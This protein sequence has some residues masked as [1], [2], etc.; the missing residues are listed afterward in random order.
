MKNEETNYKVMLDMLENLKEQTETYTN[1]V[2]QQLENNG[3]S[4]YKLRETLTDYTEED[5][6]IIDIKVLRDIMESAVVND[7]LFNAGFDGYTEI[8]KETAGY[9][10]YLRDTAIDALRSINDVISSENEVN[11]LQKN[12]DE[13]VAEY[14]EYL[15]SDKYYEENMKRIEK[16]KNDLN[17]EKDPKMKEKIGNMIDAMENRYTL[18]F[19][20]KRLNE[21][22]DK[23]VDRLVD[24]FFD[25]NRSQ[26]IMKRYKTKTE[27]LG[28]HPDVYKYFLNLEEK[29]LEEKYYVFNNLFV[30]V[31][32]NFIAYIDVYNTRDKMYAQS[33]INSMANVVYEKFPNEK[34]KQD[35]LNIMRRV[36]DFFENYREVFNEKN[37]LH[38]NHPRRIE[39]D[40]E[41]EKELREMIYSNLEHI[42]TEVNRDMSIDDLKKYYQDKLD[43]FEAEEK[44]KVQKTKRIPAFKDDEY[45]KVQQLSFVNN[46]NELECD[47]NSIKSIED[48]AIH[49][50]WIFRTMRIDGF[51]TV[52]IYENFKSESNASY[53]VTIVDEKTNYIGTYKYYIEA[54]DGK[55]YID[56]DYIRYIIAS[57]RRNLPNAKYITD[58][59][60]SEDGV[61]T[62]TND[63][64]LKA[65]N[66]FHELLR[67]CTCFMLP[68]CVI[69]DMHRTQIRGDEILPKPGLYNMSF[70]AYLYAISLNE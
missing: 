50:S 26:Y 41:R 57:I 42:G 47:E 51:Y 43:E 23:E 29:Y 56:A 30:F 5:L 11:D 62:I 52:G 70:M 38:P 58:V 2:K 16:L 39:K 40:K 19:M 61:Y 44:V 22:G 35:F 65:L 17:E 25:D 7:N 10:T 14:A 37:I 28:Y 27:K 66:K 9:D 60:L 32:M 48:D 54:G 24:I 15:T 67:E 55:K 8:E 63:D 69:D 45:E 36:L 34:T 1:L 21:L 12:A 33:I 20:F 6:K 31:V 64:R 4:Y 46:L 18:Q 13:V 3:L 49:A 68:S 53:I 59:E